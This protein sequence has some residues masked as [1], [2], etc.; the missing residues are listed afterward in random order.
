MPCHPD[1]WNLITLEG[2][3]R[4]CLVLGVAGWHYPFSCRHLGRRD[5][6]S[7]EFKM[8]NKTPEIGTEQRHQLLTSA[9]CT[10]VQAQQ[11]FSQNALFASCNDCAARAMQVAPS[12]ARLARSENPKTR[13]VSMGFLFNALHIRCECRIIDKSQAINQLRISPADERCIDCAT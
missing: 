9:P 8:A 4:F 5:A 1:D 13:R 3:W 11:H 2:T 6:R 10:S 7:P 12:T